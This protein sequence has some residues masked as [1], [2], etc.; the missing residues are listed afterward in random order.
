[1]DLRLIKKLMSLVRFIVWLPACYTYRLDLK[2][3]KTLIISIQPPN[4][5]CKYYLINSVNSLT[6]WS[7]T[8][9][10]NLALLMTSIHPFFNKSWLCIA[11]SYI[12]LCLVFN[13]IKFACMYVGNML[14]FFASL[15][16]DLIQ[17][18]AF[19]FKCF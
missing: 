3:W 15:R 10:N 2:T 19:S 13:L 14:C 7:S 4:N 18:F 9:L 17:V 5:F 11:P 8:K 6:P 1:M 12:S 16:Y